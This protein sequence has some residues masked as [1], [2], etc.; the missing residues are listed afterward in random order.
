MT[1]ICYR[2]PCV[3][4]TLQVIHIDSTLNQEGWMSKF[5]NVSSLYG[6]LSCYCPEA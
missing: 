4:E 1:L 6:K 3:T 2:H 5:F